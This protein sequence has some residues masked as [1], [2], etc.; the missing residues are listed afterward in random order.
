MQTPTLDLAF[1]T[2]SLAFLAGFLSFISPCV[3]PLVPA[4]IGY[5]G[6]R[7]TNTVAAQAAGGA[8]PALVTAPSLLQ[9]FTIFAHAL[10]FVGGFSF[11]FVVL[12][13]LGTAFVAQI[14][15]SN[16]SLIETLITQVGGLLVIFF[17]LHL[18]GVWHWLFDRLLARPRLIGSPLFSLAF[19]LVGSG[20]I[21]WALT[22]HPNPDFLLALPVL[23]IFAFWLLLGG[24][25]NQPAA[26]WTRT[27]NS[28]TAALYSD[29][30]R[31]LNAAGDQSFATSALMG[32]VFAAGWTP[33]IGPTYGAIL[34]VAANGG[35]PG[36]AGILLTAY[37]LGLGVPFLV[38]ALLFDS[39]QSLLRR[40][41][42]H[43]GKI[44]RLTGVLLVVVGIMLASGQL[45]RISATFASQFTAFST[46]VE[47]CVIGWAEGEHAFGDI[48]GCLNDE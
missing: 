19:A 6:G 21:V 8:G 47:D 2:L 3:L 15:R 31:H 42:R 48:A 39:T 22:Y 37:S 7:L 20:L 33:C 36:Q 43:V 10:A 25:F 34:T 17:G 13:V 32:V 16:I 14:G 44:E 38:A 1:P 30:R 18:L 29:T 9:R 12:G 23:V 11:I 41:Q 27:L 35:D 26:F 4:Y 5:M 40:I 45:Q 46:N 24:A 28:L